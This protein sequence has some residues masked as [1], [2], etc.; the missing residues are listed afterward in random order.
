MVEL[1]QAPRRPRPGAVRR[2]GTD[3]RLAALMIVA[4]LLARSK[5]PSVAGGR[6]T[7]RVATLPGPSP[8]ARGAWI[9]LPGDRRARARR[10]GAEAFTAREGARTATRP[11]RPRLPPARRDGVLDA[12]PGGPPETPAHAA[13]CARRSPPARR[14][15]RGRALIRRHQPG[16]RRPRARLWRAL[17]KAL[18]G[19][20]R[21]ALRARADVRLQH[22][23][24][25]TAAVMRTHFT[26]HGGRELEHSYGE[27]G[28]ELRFR[29]PL[30][31]CAS[32]ERACATRRERRLAQ[33]L[34][35]A[36][37]LL[38]DL[39]PGA[40]RAA[41]PRAGARRGSRPELSS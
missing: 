20:I 1:E 39:R 2:R 33:R 25:Q 31:G 12:M 15:R 34:G 21:R 40:P 7:G 36:V 9:A 16:R 13:G 5:Y 6:R 29:V 3:D 23:H 27:G 30:A 41:C 26:T 14:R 37:P 17:A 24:E 28:V 8:A 10:P 22:A 32:L 38:G 18:A 35:E 11:R 19:C 4:I